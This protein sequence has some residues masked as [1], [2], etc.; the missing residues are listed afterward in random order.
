MPAR[1]FTEG[2]CKD[3]VK[4][5]C[6]DVKPGGGDIH[7]CLKQHEADLSQACKDNIA[8]GKQKMKDKMDEIK[9]ACKQDLQQYC[10]SVTPG[11]GREMACLRSYSDKLSAACKEKLPRRPMGQRIHHEKKADT[12]PPPAGQ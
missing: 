8:E 7:E 3:D 11:E 9:A 10:A 12:P 5:L 1:A 2:A 6:G 4:K